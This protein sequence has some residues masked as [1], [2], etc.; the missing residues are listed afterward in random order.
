MGD[1]DGRPQTTSAASASS[2]SLNLASRPRRPD[3]GWEAAA[4]PL[5]PGLHISEAV[6]A[7]SDLGWPV[8]TMTVDIP[9][10]VRA[11]ATAWVWLETSRLDTETLS[12]MS[13][14]SSLSFSLH[15]SLD[16]V[17]GFGDGA[18][19]SGVIS[20]ANPAVVSRPN[21]EYG[22]RR[23]SAG[24]V[25]AVA[26]RSNRPFLRDSRVVSLKLN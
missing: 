4:P 23:E 6:S 19:T 13:S 8:E 10:Q 26:R 1:P 2:A 25:R 16:K 14:S 15:V 17:S 12:S 20:L 7:N 5:L 11:S 21:P 9:A 3:G 24:V 18:S 22:A